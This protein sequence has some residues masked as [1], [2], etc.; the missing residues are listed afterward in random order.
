VQQDLDPD[1]Q[2]LGNKEWKNRPILGG[3]ME[4]GT[5][6]GKTGSGGTPTGDD[7]ARENP[8]LPLLETR[9]RPQKMENLKH[10]HPTDKRPN[11]NNN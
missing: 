11:H 2:L 9:N 5:Q 8:S 10:S 6:N 7:G 4:K 1:T 3:C